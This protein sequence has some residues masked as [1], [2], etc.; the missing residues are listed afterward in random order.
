[1]I[2]FRRM[3]NPPEAN[4]DG[5]GWRAVRA[6]PC[7]LFRENRM[8]I[9]ATCIESAYGHIE[10]DQPAYQPLDSITVHVTG[11]ADGDAA[12]KGYFSYSYTQ[13]KTNQ[14]LFTGSGQRADFRVLLPEG[15]APSRV[16]L[17]SQPVDFQMNS[18]DASRYAQVWV[19][20][21]RVQTLEIA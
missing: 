3:K 16:T 20:V 5:R 21:E 8:N 4:I 17:N 11:R 6:I 1:M 14:I 7:R 18:E 9:H 15:F 13:S 10:T 12:S 2:S 19:P